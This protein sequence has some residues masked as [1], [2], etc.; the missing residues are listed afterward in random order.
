MRPRE[1]RASGESPLSGRQPSTTLLL[2][3]TFVMTMT[4]RAHAQ[5]ILP[6]GGTVASGQVHIGTPAGNAL[7]I[8]Q[9]SSKAIVDWNSFS[10][11][12]NASVNIVQP[13]SSAA[14]LNRVTG[15]TP[16]TIA[17]Q[18]NANGQVFLVNPN[19]IAITPT[20]S[21]QV[22]GGFVASTLDIANADFNAGKLGFTGKGASAPVSNAGQISGAPGSFVGLV[23][24]TVS[25]SGTI[26]VPLGKVGLGAGEKVTLNPT[27]DGFLQVALPTSATTSD[28]K[29]LIDVGGRIRAAGG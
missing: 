4:A 6:Q 24:G 7:T 22:G 11:G 19:G 9:G 5:A 17:G 1:T 27:G 26:T 28:G 18:I 3:C 10:V 29:A 21:V 23:G 13:N 14:I 12:S 8:N 16:S 25:N 20:G 2:V 15:T